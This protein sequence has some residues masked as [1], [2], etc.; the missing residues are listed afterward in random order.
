MSESPKSL[1]IEIHR[2]QK[3]SVTK[4]KKIRSKFNQNQ[5]QNR[6]KQFFYTKRVDIKFQFPTYEQ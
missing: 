2:I 5:Y 4:Y 3:D 6:S 1:D